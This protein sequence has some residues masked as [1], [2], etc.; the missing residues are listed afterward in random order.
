MGTETLAE[1]FRE[2]EA[3]AL[4]ILRKKTQRQP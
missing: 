1:L 4:R 3:D 2:T